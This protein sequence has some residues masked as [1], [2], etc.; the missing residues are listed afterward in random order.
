MAEKPDLPA[1]PERLGDVDTRLTYLKLSLIEAQYAALAKHVVH[2]AWSQVDY[3]AKLLESET[4]L[5]HDR[6]TESRIQLARFPVIK[7]VGQF[8]HS[9][10]VADTVD[11]VSSLRYT[12]SS[13][14]P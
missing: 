11:L 7:T 1:L 3:L 9:H 5:R 2:K 13:S 8:R 12:P 10:A 14:L 4:D 6:T